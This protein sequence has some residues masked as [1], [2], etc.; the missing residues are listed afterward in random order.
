MEE[1]CHHMEISQLSSKSFCWKWK[2]FKVIIIAFK[3]SNK[4]FISK[5]NHKK[6]WSF[7]IIKNFNKLKHKRQQQQIQRCSLHFIEI[8]FCDKNFSKFNDSACVFPNCCGITRNGVHLFFLHCVPKCTDVLTTL[9]HYAHMP[10]SGISP[11]GY[12]V[13]LFPIFYI[14]YDVIA[15]S[16]Q[17]AFRGRI[18]PFVG[19]DLHTPE[20]LTVPLTWFC[21]IK[22]TYYSHNTC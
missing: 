11:K 1:I 15:L 7:K 16:S 4:T 14:F 17:Y 9:W 8:I 3:S 21:S 5:L 12:D 20:M 18:C 22:N 2:I 6:G 10:T 19:K 13:S